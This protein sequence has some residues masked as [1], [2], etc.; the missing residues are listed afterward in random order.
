MGAESLIKLGL[1][2]FVATLVTSYKESGIDTIIRFTL[3][4]LYFTFTLYYKL[5]G[6]ALNASG[7]QCGLNLTPKYRRELKAHKAVKNA[8]CLLGIN[9]IHVKMTGSFYG[10]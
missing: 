10:F 7:R 8:P 3:K 4:R 2:H 1:N 5:H 9:Q 6:Y